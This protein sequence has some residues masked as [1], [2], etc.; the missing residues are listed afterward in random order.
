MCSF[1]YDNIGKKWVNTELKFG[2]K[3]CPNAEFFLVRVQS[4]YGKIRTRKYLVFG[5][6]LRSWK[7]NIIKT[8][9]IFANQKFYLPTVFAEW[10]KQSSNSIKSFKI[11]LTQ[12]YFWWIIVIVLLYP[13]N[14]RTFR[15]FAENKR[16]MCLYMEMY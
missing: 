1:L 6:F 9:E 11:C 15:K 5:H 10:R 16:F 7:L 4:K 2:D 12:I 14:D 3:K 13:F 8:R